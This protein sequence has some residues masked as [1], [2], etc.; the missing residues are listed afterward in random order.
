MST[1]TM[2]DGTQIYYKIGNGSADR[3]L[4]RLAAERGRLGSADAVFASM[5]I[6]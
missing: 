5:A 4:A 1:I 6:A 2:K 3:F